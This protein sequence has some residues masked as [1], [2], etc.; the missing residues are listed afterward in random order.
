[1]PADPNRVSTIF[2]R[3]RGVPRADRPP[4]LAAELLVDVDRCHSQCDAQATDAEE[5]QRHRKVAIETLRQA[6]KLGYRHE[7]YLSTE[8]D[9]EPLR[10]VPAFTKVVE[11][12]RSS[13]M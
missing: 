3:A 5:Q 7:V 9:L 2:N 6:L 4:M 8:I 11:A 10:S 12:A 13:G 1:M